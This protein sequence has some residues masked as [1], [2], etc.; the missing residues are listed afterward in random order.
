MYSKCEAYIANRK[1]A[2]T[3]NYNEI[4]DFILPIFF[5]VHKKLLKECKILKDAHLNFKLKTIKISVKNVTCSRTF[6]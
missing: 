3:K 1:K 5:K 2:K 4:I 6:P